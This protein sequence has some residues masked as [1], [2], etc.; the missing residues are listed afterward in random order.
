MYYVYL[1]I[2]LWVTKFRYTRTLCFSVLNVGTLCIQAQIQHNI[3]LYHYMGT[4]TM[5]KSES[6]KF[7]NNN[8]SERGTYYLINIA[9]AHTSFLY[10]WGGQKKLFKPS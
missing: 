2:I 9:V 5:Y 3:R 8:V 4:T 10:W 6:E 1:Y 7:F